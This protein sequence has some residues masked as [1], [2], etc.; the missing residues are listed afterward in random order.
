MSWAFS[1]G[2]RDKYFLLFSL[3]EGVVRFSGVI[4]T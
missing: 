3:L 1:G 4:S 2:M